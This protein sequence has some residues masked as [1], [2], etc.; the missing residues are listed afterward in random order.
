[1]RTCV[2]CTE[3]IPINGTPS[4]QNTRWPHKCYPRKRRLPQGAANFLWQGA[5]E[6]QVI[7]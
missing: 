5:A 6:K 4:G 7:S 2:P 3:A 1:L